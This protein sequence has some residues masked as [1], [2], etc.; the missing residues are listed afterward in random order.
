METLQDHRET[1][2]AFPELKL[3]VLDLRGRYEG[4]VAEL[5]K[6]ERGDK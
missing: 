4:A 3:K 1:M 6:Y 5:V 2:E